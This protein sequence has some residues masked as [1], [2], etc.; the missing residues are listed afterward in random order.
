LAASLIVP[1]FIIWQLNKT[2]FSLYGDAKFASD[3]D[4]K[5]KAAKMGERKRRYT[6]RRL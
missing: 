3:D 1:V 4:L 5:I 2:D 6:C